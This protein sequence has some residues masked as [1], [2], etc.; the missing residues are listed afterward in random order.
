MF[1]PS[2]R[3]IAVLVLCAV[4]A[5]SGALSAKPRAT[6]SPDSVVV[7]K[8]VPAGLW[9]TVWRFLVSVW[10]KN[11]GAS[12]PY[13]G[14]SNGQSPPPSSSDNGSSGDPYGVGH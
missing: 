3:R 5:G 10:T 14:A 8:G 6:G 7:T 13:G 9:D 4:L 12:D 2:L 1:R 11:G